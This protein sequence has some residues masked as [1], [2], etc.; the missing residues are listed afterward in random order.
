M[1]NVSISVEQR[2]SF[3]GMSI[4]DESDFTDDIL[5]DHEE[6]ITLLEKRFQQIRPIYLLIEKRENI[7]HERTEYEQLQ[8]YPERFHQRGSALM[9]QLMKEEKMC[10]MLFN[11]GK[12]ANCKS[13]QPSVTK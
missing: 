11:Q 1:N 4:S 2:S 3:N 9:K 10:R 6:Y 8:K 13:S 5:I 7:L 12:T